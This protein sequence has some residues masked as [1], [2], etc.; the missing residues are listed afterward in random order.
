[1]SEMGIAP[2]ELRMENFEINQKEIQRVT[3][4]SLKTVNQN[5]LEELAF[6]TPPDCLRF[7]N[8][9]SIRRGGSQS[10]I[11]QDSIFE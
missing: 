11:F 8:I 9:Q 4:N 7:G 3:I 6:Q 2:T 1:M 10:E 5:E